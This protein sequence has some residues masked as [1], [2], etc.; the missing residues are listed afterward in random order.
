MRD[1]RAVIAKFKVILK[2]L[3]RKIPVSPYTLVAAGEE[4]ADEDEPELSENDRQ[5]IQ[6]LKDWDLWGPLILCLSLAIILSFKAPVGQAS[7]VFASVFS[8]VW[9]GGV[10]VT[11]NA[12]L[13]GGTISFFQSL[14]VLGYST[15]PL[16]IAALVI[17][18]LRILVHTWWW[19]D[20]IFIV[21]GFA[22]SIRVSSVFI[23]LYIRPERRFLALYPVFF[24]YTFLSWMILLF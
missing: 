16:T 11:M 1:V 18:L 21:V 7:L 8:T 15:F 5:I 23:A 17:G 13:L 10:V 6:S 19:I 2:P 20:L 4:T 14:C 9:V 24:Y 22:W 12:Q 3:D